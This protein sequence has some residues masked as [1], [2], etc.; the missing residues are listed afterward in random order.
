MKDAS[1]VH[2]YGYD[3]HSG[4]RLLTDASGMVTDTWDYD[5][6]GNVLSRTGTTANAFLY[7]GEQ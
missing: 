5:A 7:R 3:A 1:G 6:F 2:Y 4:V